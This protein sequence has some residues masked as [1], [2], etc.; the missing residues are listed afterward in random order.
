MEDLNIKS[1]YNISMPQTDT[2]KRKAYNREYYLKNKEKNK[3]I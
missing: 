1:I 3:K 2:E